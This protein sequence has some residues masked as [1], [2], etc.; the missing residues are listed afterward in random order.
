V[1][2]CGFFVLLV[3]PLLTKGAISFDEKQKNEDENTNPGI[4]LPPEFV[5]V[6]DFRHEFS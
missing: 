6:D 1:L 4:K 5:S 2:G 3:T